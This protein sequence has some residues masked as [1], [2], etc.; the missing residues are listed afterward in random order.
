[1][2]SGDDHKLSVGIGRIHVSCFDQLLDDQKKA[3][4]PQINSRLDKE[5]EGMKHISVSVGDMAA[6]Q[7]A[8]AVARVKT[9][10]DRAKFSL[11]VAR[12]NKRPASDQL[13]FK[14]P[15]S[16]SITPSPS[17]AT[18]RFKA[19]PTTGFFNS[20]ATVISSPLQIPRTQNINL[21]GPSVKI[22]RPGNGEF[23]NDFVRSEFEHVVSSTPADNGRPIHQAQ[24]H[25]ASKNTPA[26]PIRSKFIDPTDIY[27]EICANS[28]PIPSS[29]SRESVFTT[30]DFLESVE[31]ARRSIYHTLSHLVHTVTDGEI[32]KNNKVNHSEGSEFH[33]V[34]DF[35]KGRAKAAVLF[36]EAHPENDEEDNDK[37]DGKEE[38]EQLE[39]VYPFGGDAVE[40]SEEEFPDY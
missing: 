12:S 37:E 4:I 16:C 28:P 19:E 14:G 2:L 29:A 22:A 33:A 6:I 17:P 27:A 11:S 34:L 23:T 24:D 38:D 3:N 21:F 7:D 31:N 8:V 35:V 36:S 30:N 18:K 10:A 20:D 5:I 40:E 39:S 13:V 1:M 9:L 32:A 26:T 25:L 15:S